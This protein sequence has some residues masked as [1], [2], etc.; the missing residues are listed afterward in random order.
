MKPELY[1]AK[2]YVEAQSGC[3]CHYVRSDTEFFQLHYHNYYE[4]F[5]VVKGDV[6][7]VVN[8]KEQLLSEGQL[9]FIRDFDAHE[10]VSRNGEY[11]EFINF[12][13]S[14]ETLYAMIDFMGK[15]Y[16]FKTLMTAEYPPVVSL[17]PDEKEHL[18]YSLIE[19][20]QDADQDVVKL[21]ART[22]LVHVFTRFFHNYKEQNREI[23]SWLAI[24]YEKMKQPQNFT[25]GAKQMYLLS[26]KSREHLTRCM[27]QYY[28]TTPT[29][30]VSELRLAHAANLLLVSNLNVTDICY[31]CGFEN[32]SWFYKVFS[33]KYGVT[34]TEYR[35]R[36]KDR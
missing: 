10:Y 3:L 21:K 32:L 9:L 25:A 13:F 24:T 2:E 6:C 30:Y 17:P 36:Y 12:A 7:H 15:G 11:F 18:A 19:L 16:P 27:K 29:V 28:H 23:P 33:A 35:R 8:G 4:L 31:E 22:L 5:L 1:D 20:Y 26:G 34:P 14:K